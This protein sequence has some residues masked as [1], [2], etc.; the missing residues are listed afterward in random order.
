M[1]TSDRDVRLSPAGSA[2]R[3]TVVPE[4]SYGEKVVAVGGGSLTGLIVVTTCYGLGKVAPERYNLGV[5]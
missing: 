1:A 5:I 2:P 3:G 4:R